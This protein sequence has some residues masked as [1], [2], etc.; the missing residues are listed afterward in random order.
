M[1]ERGADALGEP[2]V[3]KNDGLETIG[4]RVGGGAGIAG[5]GGQR[6]VNR[7]E[8]GVE[9]PGIFIGELGTRLDAIADL[10]REIAVACEGGARL[11]GIPLLRFKRRPERFVPLLVEVAEVFDDI[12]GVFDVHVD[13]RI[14]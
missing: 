5:F 14:A 9:Q 13:V 8:R 4:F 10:T 11:V 6:F 1:F 3:V 12:L 2:L 7:S